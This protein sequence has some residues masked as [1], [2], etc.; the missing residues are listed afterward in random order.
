MKKIIKLAMAMLAILCAFPAAAYRTASESAKLVKPAE[1]D[2]SEDT[3]GEYRAGTDESFTVFRRSEKRYEKMT[4][5]EYCV[6][7]VM[8]QLP[9]ADIADGAIMAQTCAARTYAVRRK[10]VSASSGL[11]YD[12]TDDES[13]YQTCPSKEEAE[14][15]FSAVFGDDYPDL[16]R[17]VEMACSETEDMIIVSGGE[18]VI[19]AFHTANGGVTESAENVWGT[20]IPYLVPVESEGDRGS[21]YYGRKFAFTRAEFDARIAAELPDADLSADCKTVSVTPSGTVT[22]FSVGG[23]M[24]SGAEIAE[25]FTLPSA[26]FEFSESEDTVIFTVSGCGHCVGMSICGADSM[27]R[28]GADWQEILDFYYP[29]ASAVRVCFEGD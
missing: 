13:L 29:G 6:L 21:E 17:R 1:A 24:L 23:E 26:V 22:E 28:S 8:S 7:A 2:V 10:L 3:H 20:K 14:I 11:D 27:A 12:I 19:A 9:S 5:S 16:L 25:I 4:V 15:V 18:P